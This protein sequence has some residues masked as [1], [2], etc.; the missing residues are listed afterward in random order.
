METSYRQLQGTRFAILTSLE[1]SLIS[2][3]QLLPR[4]LKESINPRSANRGLKDFIPK[5]PAIFTRSFPGGSFKARPAGHR[6]GRPPRTSCKHSWQEVLLR[7]Y[8]GRRCSRPPR[9]TL[10][11]PLSHRPK[12]HRRD[13]PPDNYPSLETDPVS[14]I[15]TLPDTSCLIRPFGST[16]AT[17]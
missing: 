6:R 16:R 13:R 5:D 11:L 17:E 10:Q 8:D 15:F 4:L 12:G 7:Q 9:S 1:Q 2:T 14:M 3:P